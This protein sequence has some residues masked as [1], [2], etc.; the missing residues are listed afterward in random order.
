MNKNPLIG[1]TITAFEMTNDRKA[2]RFV[3]A[4]GEPV[5]ALCDADCCSETWIEHVILPE[6]GFPAL[7]LDA[8]D[9]EMPDLGEMP[10][11]D[12]V[13]YYGFKA[14][15]DKGE[16]VVDYRNDSNGYYGGNLTWPG[17]CHYGGVFRQNVPIL[18]WRG[19]TQDE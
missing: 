9:I 4:D 2:M 6:R 18:E 10:D 19:V 16:I 8:D 14:V 1:K 13:A 12:V 3:V 11:R 17:Q 15:T 7:V 5:V